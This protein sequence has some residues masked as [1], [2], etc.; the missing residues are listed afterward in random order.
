MTIPQIY[1]E[2]GKE[3][4]VAVLTLAKGSGSYK[5]FGD[6]ITVLFLYTQAERESLDKTIAGGSLPDDRGV[7]KVKLLGYQ[8]NKDRKKKLAE[9]GIHSDD[10]L[11]IFASPWPADN[12]FH[13]TQ[14]RSMRTIE[15]ES[16]PLPRGQ[17]FNWIY[18]YKKQLIKSGAGMYPEERTFYLA[19]RL[20]FERDKMTEHEKNEILENGVLSEAIK[21]EF[22]GIKHQKGDITAD[23]KVE[24][25]KLLSKR[26]SERK[27]ILDGYLIE[28][29]SSLKKLSQENIEQ[30][31]DLLIKTVHFKQRRPKR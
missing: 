29:G 17:D 30:A 31:V 6:S 20:Y 15:I 12:L 24:L 27:K 16:K 18:G 26:K 1:K 2:V 9:S 22:F 23:E 3:D 21:F 28:A 25:S 4:K 5:E 10:I 13:S 8:V 14:K 11:S 7:V 19:M